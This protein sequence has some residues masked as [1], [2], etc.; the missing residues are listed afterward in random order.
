MVYLLNMKEKLLA[1]A[2][3]IIY[4]VFPL[5]IANKVIEEGRYVHQVFG[6]FI[7]ASCWIP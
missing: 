1:Q 6:G 5:K 3:M 4:G 2:K 7:I